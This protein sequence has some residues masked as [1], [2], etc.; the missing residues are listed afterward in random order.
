MSNAAPPKAPEEWR[1]FT[2]RFPITACRLKHDGLKRLYRII[3]ERQKEYRDKIGATLVQSPEESDERFL[4][5][6]TT[7]SSAFVVS[8]TIAAENGEHLTGN[9]EEIFDD[10][11]FP[12]KVRSVFYSTQSVPSAVL[13]HLPQDRITLFLDF[14][15][16][17]I[18]DFGRLPTLPTLN[19]SN[20]EIS[21][22]NAAW[23]SAA[24]AKLVEFFYERRSGYEWLH[25]TGVYDI[26]SFI[27]G[28]PLGIWSCVK[29]EA[30][31]PSIDNL[32][33]IPRSLIYT[34]LFAISLLVFRILFSYSRWVLPKVEIEE[35]IRRTPLRHRAVWLFVLAAIFGPGVYDVAKVIA[36]HVL[37]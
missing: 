30:A 1:N 7:V 16:P 31:V 8:V 13:Q 18:L 29:M 35:D 6:K 12:A 36:T 20:F 19:E 14:S 9:K 24:K 5:R 25:R 26:L 2:T 15:Q 3:D 28:F 32:G 10:I 17:P 11:N 37:P 22:N 34:Y 4:Q 21:A 27:F 33:V 23:F